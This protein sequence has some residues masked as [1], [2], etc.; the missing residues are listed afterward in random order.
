VDALLYN[1]Y[2]AEFAMKYALAAFIMFAS[3]SVAFATGECEQKYPKPAQAA[4]RMKCIEAKIDDL[5]TTMAKKV[6]DFTKTNLGNVKVQSL[7]QRE[8]CANND[9]DVLMNLD[10][11]TRPGG[12]NSW[13][14][15]LPD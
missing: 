10:L 1:N 7:T 5:N 2:F 6:K 14:I 11:C 8:K 12:S 3:S 4:D 15:L 9:R 13:A